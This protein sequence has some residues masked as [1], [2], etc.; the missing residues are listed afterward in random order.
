[1]TMKRIM[2]C[3]IAALGLLVGGSAL[4]INPGDTV[5]VRARD[6]HAYPKAAKGKVSGTPTVLQ[7][8]SAAYKWQKNE[9]TWNQLQTPNGKSL[10]VYGPNLSLKPPQQELVASKDGAG[11]RTEMSAADAIKGLGA[12]AQWYAGDLSKEKGAVAKR[13]VATAEAISFHAGQK[14]GGG[15]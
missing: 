8:S 7:P 6:T 12:G 10:W 15:K 14:T 3:S 11:G 4:A 9:G 5:Y 13:S 2:S 1:M